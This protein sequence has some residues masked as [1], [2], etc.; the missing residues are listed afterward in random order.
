MAEPAK[1]ANNESA[2]V[3]ILCGSSILLAKRIEV[4]PLLKKPITF[5]GYWSI[6]AGS[7]DKNESP[8]I[9]AC[10]ELKEET[11][12]SLET[13]DIDFICSYKNPH[14]LLHL[15]CHKSDSLLIPKLNFEHTQ[16]GWFDI[17]SLDSFT[18]KIDLDLIKVIQNFINK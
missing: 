4:C 14:G 12:I 17:N 10:R 16:F 2:G 9:C 18:D 13:S 15:Y 5:G 3:A 11:Q 7:M 1:A 6:F 8:C